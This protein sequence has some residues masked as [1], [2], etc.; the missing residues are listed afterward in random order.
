MSEERVVDLRCLDCGGEFASADYPEILRG[1]PGCGSDA[2]PADPR[3]DADWLLS[4]WEWRV[5]ATAAVLY[6]YAHNGADG[7]QR[8]AKRLWLTVMGSELL[9]PELAGVSEAYIRESEEHQPK[10]VR[11]SP[12]EIRVLTFWTSGL[13]K[14]VGEGQTAITDADVEPILTKI[15]HQ[16]RRPFALTLEDE[17]G[18]IRQQFP[19]S[20][21]H[22]VYGADAKQ[23][24]GES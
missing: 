19:N 2:V 6:A 20:E 21:V 22:V 16:Q 5:M 10:G 9:L 18:E 1:C 15:R 8:C 13:V 3:A 11:C 7:M 4:E 12:H 23:A 14:P 24:D 17:I